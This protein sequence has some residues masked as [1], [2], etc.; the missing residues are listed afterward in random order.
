MPTNIGAIRQDLTLSAYE[1]W[2]LR[3]TVEDADAAVVDITGA[4]ATWVLKYSASGVLILRK[5]VGN[6]I[7]LTAPTSGQLTVSVSETETQHLQPAAYYHELH[8]TLGSI[9]RKAAF[10]SIVVRATGIVD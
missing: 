1:D 5:T 10:G 9:T 2:P 3:F 6:G 4:T 7:A 8:V